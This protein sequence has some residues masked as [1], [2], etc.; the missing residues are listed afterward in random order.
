MSVDAAF[1]M[2]CGTRHRPGENT[3]CP[4]Y[5]PVADDLAPTADLA[6][7]LRREAE[8]ETVHLSAADLIPE[9][10][11]CARTDDDQDTRYCRECLQKPCRW[12]GGW[13]PELHPEVAAELQTVVDPSPG[14]KTREHYQSR[15]MLFS[16]VDR[17][18]RGRVRAVLPDITLEFKQELDQA[19]G[20]DALRKRVQRVHDGIAKEADGLEGAL[21]ERLDALLAKAMGDASN[22]IIK[23]LGE[24]VTEMVANECGLQIASLLRTSA[25][26]YK[27][28]AKKKRA[29]KKRK[30]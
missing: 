16:E 12:F 2:E 22:A 23:A 21:A 28:R 18:I 25:I 11:R 9:R 17:L 6:P 30:G 15:R 7:E 27:A 4:Q 3:L 10:A 13:R 26:V 19:L 14:N 5:R 1:C 29:R 24:Q 20:L 8:P